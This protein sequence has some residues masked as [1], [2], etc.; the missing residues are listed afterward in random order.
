MKRKHYLLIAALSL[1]L[2][3]G[4]CA[5]TLAACKDPTEN[6]QITESVTGTYYFDDNGT[7]KT[8]ILNLTS[9]ILNFGE[10]EKEGVYTSYENGTLFLTFDNSEMATAV[11]NGGTL[12]LNYNG[13]TYTLYKKIDYTVSFDTDGGSAVNVQTVTNGKK[14]ARPENPT[15]EDSV[16][17]DWYTDTSFAKKFDFD[18]PVT[19]NTTVYAKFI[20][21][22]ARLGV[23]T[24]RFDLGNGAGA[25]EN[26]PDTETLNR[27]L[28][29]L[30]EVPSKDGKKFLGWWVSNYRDSQ[31]L[32][33]KYENQELFEDTVLYAV[34]ES[35][36]PTVSVTESGANWSYPASGK[37]F[38]AFI[39][40]EKGTVLNGDGAG[41]RGSMTSLAFDFGELEAGDYTVEVK[42][43][44][45][46]TI[47]YFR[48]KALAPVS[49]FTVEDDYLG[50][51]AVESAVKDL[52]VEYYI[53]VECGDPAHTHA[54]TKLNATGYD[55][56]NCSMKQGGMRFRVTAEAGGYLSSVS[57]WFTLERELE[58]A[59]GLKVDSAKE[60]LTW[61]AVE[62]AKTYDL[63]FFRDGASE[64]TFTASVTTNSYDMRSFNPGDWTIRIT[65]KNRTYNTPESS[66]YN[67]TKERLAI[68]E[69]VNVVGDKITWNAVE[70]ATGYQLYQ[71]G[72][73]YG[74]PLTANEY[75]M[76]ADE[77]QEAGRE[78]KITV[79]ALGADA[80]QNSLE[81]DAVYIHDEFRPVEGDGYQ[82]GKVVWGPVR[83]VTSYGVTVGDGEE[84]IVQDG[85][86]EKEV[87]FTKSGT[88]VIT[89]KGYSSTGVELTQISFTVEVYTVTFN[90][91]GGPKVENQYKADGD[92]ITL[93]T[94]LE[95]RGY[96]FMGWKASA[97]GDTSFTTETIVFDKD[98]PVIYANWEAKT[99]TVRLVAGDQGTMPD[100]AQ[101]EF[102]MTFGQMLSTPLPVPKY[103][104]DGKEF[105]GWYNSV[106]GGIAYTDNTGNMLFNW[107]IDLGD[108]A[109]PVELYAQW[110]NMGVKYV[111]DG[112]QN[113]G[114][115]AT[116][117]NETNTLSTVTVLARYEG[118][119]VESIA[120]NAFSSCASI[121][122]LRIPSSLQY[123][124]IP[125]EIEEKSSTSEDWV[126]K[127]YG[128]IYQNGSSLFGMN[129]LQEIEVYE[130]EGEQAHFKSIDGCLYS[131]DEEGRLDEL[132]FV[133]NRSERTGTFT[134]AEGTKRIALRAFYSMGKVEE[135]VIPSSVTYIG[136]RAFASNKEL[137]KVTFLPAPN[138]EMG[139]PLEVESC[140]DYCYA[141]TEI[142][143]PK[144]LVRLET[145]SFLT[146]SMSMKNV[147]I[148]E[149]GDTKDRNTNYYD[150]DG[151]LCKADEIVYFP[152][153]HATTYQ[154]ASGIRTIGIKAFKNAKLTSVRM[155]PS[156]DE[157]KERAFENCN[158]LKSITFSN[159]PNNADLA[160]RRKAFYGC[161]SLASLTLPANL[162]ILEIGAFGDTASLE[163]VKVET[164]RTNLDFALGA[165]ARITVSGDNDKIGTSQIHTVYLGADV[166][167]IELMGVF[168]EM[169]SSVNIASGSSYYA[170][171]NNVIYDKQEK[172]ILFMP[173]GMTEFETS[174]KLEVITSNVFRNNTD[175]IKVTLGAAVKQIGESAF[176]GCTSL[177]EVVFKDS[178]QPLQI[179]NKAFYTCDNLLTF[180]FDGRNGAEI[181]LGDEVFASKN[182]IGYSNDGTQRITRFALPEGVTRVGKFLFSNRTN[183]TDVSLPA[184]LQH[185][186][187]LEVNDSYPTT[188]I[189]DKLTSIGVANVSL[190]RGCTSMTNVTVAE[191]NENYLS[192]DGILYLKENGAVTTLLYA[193][194]NNKAAKMP[195]EFK[196]TG[197]GAPAEQYGYLA[198]PETVTKMADF[199]LNNN[200]NIKRIAFRGSNSEFTLGNNVFTGAR[201]LEVIDL[202]SGIDEIAEGLFQGCSS[203]K[204]VEIPNTV[205]TIRQSA[206]K[207]C[208]TLEKVLFATGNDTLPLDIEDGTFESGDVSGSGYSDDKSTGA[209]AGCSALSE[210][211]FPARTRKIGNNA[212][213]VTGRYVNHVYQKGD[214]VLQSVEIPVSVEIIGTS[215]F[216]NCEQLTNITF[217]GDIPENF[218]GMEIK[219]YAFAYTG[220]TGEFSLSNAKELKKLGADVFNGTKIT[221][222]TLPASLETFEKLGLSA[223]LETLVFETVEENG[224]QVNRLASLPTSIFDKYKKL[225]SIN[226]EDCTKIDAVPASAF[227]GCVM[228]QSVSLPEQVTSIGAS[229]FDGC[230]SLDT[231][232]YV[233]DSE[234]NS[235]L[236]SIGNYAF[237]NTALTS[238]VFPTLASGNLTLGTALFAGCAQLT[239]LTISKSVQS[240][241]GALSQAPNLQNITVAE[242]SGVL[243]DATNCL[244]FEKTNDLEYKITS[245]YSAVPVDNNGTYR[246]PATFNGGTVTAIGDGAFM[247][248][249]AV[250]VFVVPSAVLSIGKQA[251]SK[252]IGLETVE[253]AEDGVIREF[254]EQAFEYT[255]SMKSLVIPNS[256]KSI[257]YQCFRYSGIQ[258]VTMP[259][260]LTT[261]GKD[262]FQYSTIK[263]VNNFPKLN[264]TNVVSN[265]DG[266]Q[267][268]AYTQTLKEITFAEGVTAIPSGMFY[269][270]AGIEEIDLTG[271]T[272]V[273]NAYNKTYAE[274]LFGGCV[275]L[276]KLILDERMTVLPYYYCF[277]KCEK[278]T[279][280]MRSDKLK[281]LDGETPEQTA[282]RI[283]AMEGI[284][285]LSQVTSL[286]G[287][288]SAFSSSASGPRIVD[289]RNLTTWVGTGS[290]FN[291]FASLNKIILS[292]GLKTYSSNMFSNLKNLKTVQY[293]IGDEVIGNEGEVTV[294]DSVTFIG[295]K[296][297]NASGVEKVIL[298]N[299]MQLIGKSAS[300]A[301]VG[302][303]S[304]LFLG[305][306]SLKEVILP[307][308]LTN[309]GANVFKN[310][311][312]LTTIGYRTGLT[313]K[314]PE[315]TLYKIPYTS[316][317]G[318]INLPSTLQSV[319]NYCFQGCTQIEKIDFSSV[320]AIGTSGSYIN[321]MFAGCTALNEIKFNNKLEVLGNGMFS[322]C[323]A[324]QNI[325]LP[326]GLKATGQH[327]FRASGLT[328]LTLPAGVQYLGTTSATA[329]ITAVTASGYVFYDC[330]S[331]VSIYLPETFKG[332]GADTF[333][334][335][336]LL[337]EYALYKLDQNGAML[338]EE[339]D[340]K[341]VPVM[342]DTTA[343]EIV[344]Q[345]AFKN[346][347]ALTAID[348]VKVTL[349]GK[350]AFEG[351]SSL[352]AADLSSATAAGAKAEK[353][354]M[355]CSALETV[356]LGENI[357]ELGVYAFQNCEALATIDLAN[358]TKLGNYAFDGCTSLAGADLSAAT[359]IGTYAFRGCSSLETV[360]LNADLTSLGNYTFNNCTQLKSIYK[361]TTAE[362]YRKPGKADLSGITS[363]GSRA[364]QGCSALTEIELSDDLTTI[365]DTLFYNC[366]ALAKI[367]MPSKLETISNQAF[368][369]CSSLTALEIPAGVTS[370]GSN[371]FIGC[372][373]LTLT[374]DI[375][376]QKFEIDG[377]GWLVSKE[378]GTVFYLPAYQ[379]DQQVS[380]IILPQGA[381][382]Y[383]Y[384]FNGYAN[385]TSVTLPNDLTEIAS[386]AFW[387]YKGGFGE[388]FTLP[389][390]LTS[391]GAN[392]F[393]NAE[394]L[395]EIVIPEGVTSIGANAF[396]GCV[397]L[398][399]VTFPYT[400]TSIGANAF[401]G[402]TSLKEFV[403]VPA[404]GHTEADGFI[405]GC[406]IGNY[407]F[408][409]CSSLTGSVALPKGI[410][411][412]GNRAFENCSGIDAIVFGDGLSKIDSYAFLGCDMLAY[413]EFGNW[414]EEGTQST[415]LINTQAFANLPALVEVKF[416]GVGPKKIGNSAFMNCVKLEAFT[417]PYSTESI[418]SYA[419][420]NCS[421]LA[422]VTFANAPAGVEEVNLSIGT[423]ALSK[424]PDE[425]YS[426]LD[427]NGNGFKGAFTGTAL[428]AISL[429]AR[430]TSIG[431]YCF[432]GMPFASIALPAGLVTIG[433][434]AFIHSGLTAVTIPYSVTTLGRS[435]FAACKN[436]ETLV[437]EATPDG[438]EPVDL[439]LTNGGKVAKDSSSYS[440]LYV[441][442][443]DEFGSS[444][445]V[446]GV[447]AGNT[448]LKA[449]NLP[450][451]IKSATGDYA[452]VGSGVTSVNLGGAVNLGDGMFAGCTQ[453]NTVTVPEGTTFID[454][455]F[456]AF[457][458]A[459]TNVTLPESITSIGANAFDGCTGIRELLIPS[460]NTKLGNYAFNG[461]TAEQ[462]VLIRVDG[463]EAL[464]SSVAWGNIGNTSA[465]IG[466]AGY[467]YGAERKEENGGNRA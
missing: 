325:E 43:D 71:N 110:G 164:I 196:E 154:I 134:V 109:T 31:K 328:T 237:R 133:P 26:Y 131:L 294:S 293:A 414:V 275:S 207:N 456:F 2:T 187:L 366:S 380:Q 158:E 345:N 65:P 119:L 73:A 466:I 69:Q 364:F 409:G 395:T 449:V 160:I 289:V 232:L 213:R 351:C 320:T 269:N 254:G 455:Y 4:V 398:K 357:T 121:K 42:V 388:N 311:T 17:I 403:F 25:D 195:D 404:A 318:E 291:G 231:F 94:G 265:Y 440:G 450:G 91:L 362:D 28:Y 430:L 347:S 150:A 399:K 280:V 186:A 290:P 1:S 9:F 173:K 332:I 227:S 238:F 271:I 319:G 431:S 308:D 262:M 11:Y 418:D 49:K 75:T 153:Y 141:L 62:N 230:T 125:P 179:D 81:S 444:N 54:R 185:I 306:E 465:F 177:R 281:P 197:D 161:G 45:K 229:A 48:N 115:I 102:T 372:N 334:G 166:P 39:K 151:V 224:K 375:A 235:N 181:T 427:E 97:D 87:T 191:G 122:K 189:S 321:G 407:A 175:L 453:L 425:S 214:T 464:P 241:G 314:D 82:N 381:K 300:S 406:T 105:T 312:A 193:G 402:C 208:Y 370:V 40:D 137:K 120:S 354:F 226:L 6:I 112:S 168:G 322:G 251:F 155:I 222:L 202:P 263:K 286:T 244:I 79:V 429:P 33:A 64:A 327:T 167:E 385:V 394:G 359:S 369:N 452:F 324:L 304:S 78:F 223:T 438:I 273:M 20:T 172:R 266:S 256:V 124:V 12:T 107:N 270:C 138:G 225:T 329:K 299:N 234:G 439:N 15:R 457:C 460:V 162:K 413:V 436:L 353:L 317:E 360:V 149:L 447:F 259:D 276:K 352:K 143:F 437:F 89:V 57:E 218:K 106:N 116:K 368:L 296:T 391:I 316:T 355:G 188:N 148:Q 123:L 467:D 194:P 219:T 278:L 338:T 420:L 55:F 416:N 211:K 341:Q 371:L 58:K 337:Q 258:E 378:D 8:I 142:T 410:T 282:E 461:W 210:I 103:N 77:F 340:G 83:G 361:S 264:L 313:E 298:P 301:A 426:Y 38:E 135:I 408:S 228:L 100:G 397:N 130:V 261:A 303:D 253:F 61:D 50:F 182:S 389:S 19:A 448:K 428:T 433:D 434:G 46:T 22:D 217:T 27:R 114:L 5:T 53:D 10:G 267:P 156:V 287:S 13:R 44:G 41:Y 16:F 215:A 463:E 60:L 157:I 24:V 247:G 113:G 145:D 446:G 108:S 205:G 32:S 233:T 190:F 443:I 30:P 84:E 432:A 295:T 152:A 412:I 297:F 192:V 379:G 23:F 346:C 451:R 170:E 367:N 209:F 203:L 415:V 249:N 51:R 35:D 309:L 90:T 88:T 376:N 201:G 242:G 260:E 37:T 184:S 435:A 405:N 216:Y 335:C 333:S 80:A 445:C 136:K 98:S 56:S 292:S 176:D 268:F 7:E 101:T 393:Q 401:Q 236:N 245:A 454:T 85:V 441:C 220:L 96:K 442:V 377:N 387:N 240:I 252:C 18:A 163:V 365:A 147:F 34:W 374:V 400:L 76:G 459:L 424:T 63:E 72:A 283:A 212:F 128:G 288:G 383:Q 350:S 59:T 358:L 118:K 180:T 206:F 29:N 68:P 93:P 257:G 323:T 392:A 67:Y 146:S 66:E 343:L 129:S 165:F 272:S 285:D 126:V 99:T 331:L 239:D 248:Q 462:K 423:G 159:N 246:I 144:R 307:G 221:G 315:T 21:I 92:E 204:E 36:H 95:R 174:D 396:N 419:F 47:A 384:M 373:K 243:I 284:V 139:E 363:F 336:D 86:N 279:T 302:D 344:G 255:Y 421:R 411:S 250:R 310:C 200:G 70:G 277:Y 199:A 339:K 274:N 356:T 14:A 183:L 348:L 3:T 111:T 140:F 132:M 127:T 326:S 52:F 198:V 386:Y 117:N 305:C 171:V 178:D 74:A 390:A 382:L 104:G 330:K 458:T 169:L 417:I 422:A 342:S 349:F